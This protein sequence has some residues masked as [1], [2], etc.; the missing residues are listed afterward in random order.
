MTT[1]LTTAEVLSCLENIEVGSKITVDF[2]LE[3]S[4]TVHSKCG[5]LVMSDDKYQLRI[6]KGT[7]FPFF[8][9]GVTYTNIHVGEQSVS[10]HIRIR[11]IAGEERTP[12]QPPAPATDMSQWQQQI[13]LQM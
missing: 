9:E 1:S 2:L 4:D 11:D 7:Y 5:V 12:A 6:S 10:P 13:Q 8:A 3:D